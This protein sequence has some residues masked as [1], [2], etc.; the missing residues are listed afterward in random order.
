MPYLLN[1]L[2]KAEEC[3]TVKLEKQKMF[4]VR[5]ERDVPGQSELEFYEKTKD[6]SNYEIFIIRFAEKVKLGL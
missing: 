2:K 5:R 4:F 6:L 1:R 3:A